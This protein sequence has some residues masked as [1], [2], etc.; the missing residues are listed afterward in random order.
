MSS[1]PGQVI[2]L[3][4]SAPI[5][6]FLCSG[7]HLSASSIMASRRKTCPSLVG[8]GSGR[9]LPP[10]TSMLPVL[11]LGPF[12]LKLPVVETLAD[13]HVE[14]AHGQGAVGAR[15]KLQDHVGVLANFGDPG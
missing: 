11:A 8:P 7:G 2:S 6:F 13:D 12:V 14:P 15:P 1:H 5:C 4:L 9:R 10:G 3:N